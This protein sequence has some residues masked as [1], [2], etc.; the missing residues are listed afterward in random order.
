MTALYLYIAPASAD[1]Y[2]Y[3]YLLSKHTF[4][5]YQKYGYSIEVKIQHHL[6]ASQLGWVI[7]YCI[8][9]WYPLYFYIVNGLVCC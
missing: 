7:M 5:K 6:I 4:Q 9:I 3:G 1:Y 8:I 2:K